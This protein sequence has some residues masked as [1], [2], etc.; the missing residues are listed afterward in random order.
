MEF[1]L[2]M[3]PVHY[4]GK[5]LQR[6]LKEDMDTVVLADQLGFHEAWIGEH[7]T[8]PWENLTSPDLFIAQALGFELTLMAQ[9]VVVLRRHDM[10]LE[11]AE[12]HIRRRQRFVGGKA[13]GLAPRLH[14][15]QNARDSIVIGGCAVGAAGRSRCG[16][17]GGCRHRANIENL[18]CLPAG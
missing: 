12:I 18:L 4:P 2:F 5:G 10:R 17:R 6:T 7:H 1:G 3:M 15:G 9:G 13:Q 16:F 11:R 8:I 14:L